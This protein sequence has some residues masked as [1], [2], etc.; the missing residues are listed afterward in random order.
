MFIILELPIPLKYYCNCNIFQVHYG[1]I[2]TLLL[3]GI[4]HLAYKVDDGLVRGESDVAHL[5]T[6][7]SNRFGN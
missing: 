3:F 7:S 5:H 1:K 4:A 6:S 2:S